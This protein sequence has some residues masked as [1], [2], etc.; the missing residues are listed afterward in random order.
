[1]YYPYLY[2]HNNSIHKAK[3]WNQHRFHNLEIFESNPFRVRII[4]GCS[5]KHC[6]GHLHPSKIISP[7]S[8]WLS[9]TGIT[10][11]CTSRHQQIIICLDFSLYLRVRQLNHNVCEWII[12]SVPLYFRTHDFPMDLYGNLQ[13]HPVYHK[14]TIWNKGLCS[15]CLG[16]LSWGAG[17][18]K[19][20]R[21]ESQ[22]SLFYRVGHHDKPLLLSSGT[23]HLVCALVAQFPVLWCKGSSQLRGP[24]CTC[25]NAQWWCSKI[26]DIPRA[27]SERRAHP[28]AMASARRDEAERAMSSY[29]LWEV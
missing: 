7:L 16:S 1:M 25:M 11:F 9:V 3:I 19:Q 12:S 4:Q 6:I 13:S 17:V 8:A 5:F 15:G 26:S 2:V 14:S 29:E 24:G 22:T 27:G 10:M 18:E 23:F 21:R 20:K 28:P